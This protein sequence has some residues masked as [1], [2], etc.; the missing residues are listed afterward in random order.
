MKNII[1]PE[2]IIS[3]IKV[4]LSSYF[5]G[6]AK[7][8]EFLKHYNIKKATLSQPLNHI[9][10]SSTIHIQYIMS[11]EQTTNG[12]IDGAIQSGLNATAFILK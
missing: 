11:G 4:K 2:N 9:F 3:K 8:Y 10:N 6:N 7:D 12:S 1:S 5:G